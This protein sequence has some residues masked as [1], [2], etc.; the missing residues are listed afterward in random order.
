MVTAVLEN[1]NVLARWGGFLALSFAV[2]YFALASLAISTPNLNVPPI[3][4]IRISLSSIAAPRPVAPPTPA[5]AEAV[6]AA[7]QQVFMPA[8]PAP[9]NLKTAKIAQEKIALPIEPVE[10]EVIE[11]AVKQLAKSEP[12]L[13]PT[14][15]PRTRPAHL[16]QQAEV[17]PV[18]PTVKKASIQHEIEKKEV[19][20]LEPKAPVVR[21]KASVQPSPKTVAHNTGN[22]V[23]TV[24]HTAN[25]R[26]RT[27]PVY[28][29]RAYQLG[30]Q[31]TVMLHALVDNQGRPGDLKVEKSSGYTMLDKA[32]LIAVASWEFEPREEDGRKVK[33]W[34]RV[35]VK[36][37][38]R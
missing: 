17:P 14:P 27:P 31:G 20:I 24:I 30:Q 25:Y 34:V 2:N 22:N 29:R 19:P 38:I 5:K 35:P 15:S 21:A 7:P 23:S 36:F 1:R 13:Q 8:P 32:A 4:K 18:K 33:S 12:K 37:V 28:P 6:K 16:I 10:K 9:K 3:E 26:H 11:D